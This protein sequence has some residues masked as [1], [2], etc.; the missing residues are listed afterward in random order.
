[1]TKQLF[2]LFDTRRKTLFHVLLILISSDLYS[3]CTSPSFVA[4]DR[5][6][7]KFV[8]ACAL[9]DTQPCRVIS[10]ADVQG[11]F[12]WVSCVSFLMASAHVQ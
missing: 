12:H 7:Q 1:M 11:R 10:C 9:I 8:N 4:S 6:I 2:S 5:N 3:K